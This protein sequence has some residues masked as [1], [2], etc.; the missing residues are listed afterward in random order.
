MFLGVPPE[1]GPAPAHRKARGR[2]CSVPLIK[3]HGG[4]GCGK[5]WVFN[6]S[7]LNSLEKRAFD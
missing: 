1:S 2:D 6:D 3:G 5:N 4:R 7:L